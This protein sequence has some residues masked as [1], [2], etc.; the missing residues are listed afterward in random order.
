VVLNCCDTMGNSA[1]S[2]K[3]SQLANERAYIRSLGDRYPLGDAELRKW[4][5]CHDRLSSSSPPPPVV[6]P[7]P[8]A[9]LS[10]L[11]VWSAVYSDYNPYNRRPSSNLQSHTSKNPIIDRENS[12][13]QVLE[14]INNVEQ[15]IFPAGLSS[16]IAQCALGISLE[17]KGHSPQQPSANNS[18]P[19]QSA[20]SLT[21]TEEISEFEESYYSIA[22]S[23][24]E[25]LTS[26]DSSPYDK[27]SSQS[28]SLEEF[29]EGISASCGRRGSRASL[30]KLFAIASCNNSNASTNETVQPGRSAKAEA[31]QLVRAAYSLA[32]GASYLKGVASNKKSQT[33]SWQNF[34]PQNNPKDMQSMIDSL[35]NS[36]AKQ[37]LG[38]GG[39]GGNNFGFDYSYPSATNNTAS[40]ANSDGTTTVS[41][42]EFLEWA[43]T[44]VPMM[45]SA[46]PTF[47][48]VLFTFFTPAA[49][50]DG[51]EPRFPPSVAPLW[52]PS[53]SVDRPIKST[54]S[55]PTS[56]F[57]PTPSSSSFDLFALSCTSLTLASGRWH[58]LFSSEANGTSC[59]RLM[60]SLL[61]Y[62][63]PSIVLIRSKDSSDKEKC[64]SGVFGAYTFTPWA[65]ESSGFY[66]N[67]D[68][69]LF[70][71]GPDP[72]AVYRPKGGGDTGG[73]EAFGTNNKTSNQESETCN[74][75]YFNPEARSKGYDGLA[76]GL[77]F[78]GTSD[79]PRLYIDE[80]LDG[81][82]AASE[83][84]TYE[85]GP[86]LSGLNDSNSSAASRFEVDT[87]EAWGVGTSQLV[88]DALLAR[89]G[90]RED[91]Q[92]KIRQA[93][94]G[95]KGQ[96]LEDF[97]SGLA[98]N[99]LFQHRDQ[100]RGRD[101]GCDLDEAE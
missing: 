49:P 41:S 99:K 30:S 58:R 84:L 3:Q 19:F 62:G 37:R 54:H 88:E 28:Q 90:Q 68:C 9:S 26:N 79:M 6:Q 12:V 5:W 43:E 29:L 52:M 59:N 100:A 97:Q 25:Y 63:G 80:V 78:G 46:L 31:S 14:A 73:M 65:H 45:G 50:G 27:E 33:I 66:G 23:V 8:S 17:P 15:R 2:T 56:A 64:S 61:G 36:A 51:K 70:R 39:L 89:D 85:K 32:L 57:F 40:I 20:K 10:L 92:K 95:A 74:Y 69:F 22:S 55:S 83:D 96:F 87:M 18:D 71:L 35:I 44:E 98:G 101:G 72:M 34:V 53:L 21:S 11:A 94:K 13:N 47:L 82:R 7:M 76:H 93:M 91:A 81:C 77:G 38:G 60:H 67:S 42:Q 16:C 75:M 1:S 48:H 4:C 24:K 86:L